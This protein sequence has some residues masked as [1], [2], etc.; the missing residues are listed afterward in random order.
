MHSVT[1]ITVL[2]LKKKDASDLRSV[3]LDLMQTG[4]LTQNCGFLELK[5]QVPALKQKAQKRRK[6]KRKAGEK[7]RN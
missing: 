2:N 4:S 6:E 1:F 5:A 3:C 7:K